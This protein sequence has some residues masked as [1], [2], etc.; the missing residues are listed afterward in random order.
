[1]YLSVVRKISPDTKTACAKPGCRS[2][3]CRDG[4]CSAI[5][6]PGTSSASG[7]TAPRWASPDA[8]MSG[9]DVADGLPTGGGQVTLVCPLRMSA[10]DVVDG[11]RSRHRCAIG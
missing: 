2:D 6:S 10:I 4:A 11:A 7:L 3:P 5:S 1:M 9:L 8:A